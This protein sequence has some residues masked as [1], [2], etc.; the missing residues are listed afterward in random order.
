MVN[1]E[2][3]YSNVDNLH[4]RNDNLGV[5]MEKSFNEDELADIMNEIES[6]ENG[7]EEVDLQARSEEGDIDNIHPIASEEERTH[8][9]RVQPAHH[10]EMSF[11]VEGQMNLSLGF[12][13]SGTEVQINVSEDGMQITMENGATF[14]LPVDSKNAA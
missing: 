5:S 14:H 3:S 1:V 13:I 10:S 11:H 7:S 9:T 12:V 6:L 4:E 2:K 8:D